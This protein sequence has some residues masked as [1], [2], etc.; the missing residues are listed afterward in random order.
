VYN[1]PVVSDPRLAAQLELASLPDQEYV[2]HV[3]RLFLRRDALPED[4]ERCVASLEAGTLSRA[5][6]LQELVASEEFV[7]VRA[8]DDAVAR[9]R[10]A[11]LSDERPRELTAPPGTDERAVEIAWVL[12]R[13]RGEPRVLDVGYAFGEPAY[14]SELVEL[15]AAELVGVDLAAAEVPGLRA[16]VADVR[17]LPFEDASFDVAFC[18]STVEHVG[19]DN[20]AYGVDADRDPAG[21]SRALGELKRV[22]TP[23]GRLLVTVPCGEPSDLGTFVQHDPAGWHELFEQAGLTVFEAETYELRAEGWRSSPAL[24]PSGVRYGERGPGASAVL[25]VELLC[26][27]P[28]RVARGI[29]RAL[30]REG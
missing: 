22:L 2:E 4:L 7:R 28:R 29:A 21:A 6:L 20:R 1:T 12:A 10:E 19:L 8:L 25:C 27:K 15:G 5:T 18:I 3:Y 11:R 9:A 26:R 30:G 13:Y 16:V 17:E 14:L 24:E 23:D